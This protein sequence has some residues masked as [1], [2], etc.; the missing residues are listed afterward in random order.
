MDKKGFLAIILI[1]LIVIIWM[2][3]QGSISERQAPPGV[4]Q[5]QATEG[6]LSETADSLI[7]DDAKDSVTT[8]DT[9]A[10]QSKYG[11]T[12]APFAS[13]DYRTVTI[14]NKYFT[15]RLSNKGGSIKKWQLKEYD[16]WDGVPVQLIWDEKGE[17]FLEFVTYEG[18]RIDTRDL[19]FETELQKKH[20]KLGED[21]S[22]SFSYHLKIDDNKSIVKKYTFFGDSYSFKSEI[23]LKNM[24][25][26]IPSRGYDYVWANGLRYQEYNSVD[27]SQ[28]AEAIVQLNGTSAEI[29]AG[30]IGEKEMSSETGLVDYAAVKIKYFTAAI[31]PEPWRSFDGTVDVIGQ[32]YPAK[33]D[34]EVEKYDISF[35]IPYKSGTDTKSFKIYIGPLEYDRVSEYGL[36]NTVNFGWKYGIRQIGEYF[37]MP[38]FRFI[39]NFVPNYGIALIIFS[40]LIK[41]LLYP[42][43]I[44]QMRSA[45]KMKLLAPE[46]QAIR[47]KYKDDNQKQQREIMNMY[48]QYGVNPV[49]GC[50]PML[51]QMP[52]LFSLWSVLRSA[53]E[54][55]QSEFFWWITDLSTPDILV[56]F[57]FSFLGMTHLSGLALLMG[58]TMFFQQKLTI[59]DPRQKGLIYF[60][61]LFFVF[62]F[63]NFP[64]GLNLYYFMFNLLGIIQQVYINKFS[65]NKPTLE[66][67]K[68]SPKKESW[69]QKKMREAQDIAEAQG[70]SVPG[71]TPANPNQRKKKP[72]NR[73]PNKRK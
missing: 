61:P 16:K 41:L 58:I 7:S 19:Y 48:S 68:K 57:G 1:T 66:T 45:S 30:T 29:N 53:I 73:K 35:R 71:K 64:S 51:L 15:A 65:K 60:M 72:N 17:L 20:F 42:L 21:D 5:K 50:L 46:M 6:R 18:V 11:K 3:W 52:I 8:Q 22:V 36:Q 47:D 63:S 62:L 9:L 70:K 13:G 14:E 54:L 28:S 56:D 32:K 2:I 59:T 26:I 33:N 69:L 39:H 10:K 55:R 34:G 23:E 31:I 27:E 37:M 4:E 40:I 43:S 49:G 24:Q 25:D 12:F 67:M 44:Q 38:I